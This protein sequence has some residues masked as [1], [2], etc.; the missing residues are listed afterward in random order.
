M[1][2][3]LNELLSVIRTSIKDGVAEINFSEDFLRITA[4]RKKDELID[5]RF[6]A[7][8]SYHVYLASPKDDFCEYCE[9]YFKEIVNPELSLA[10]DKT[11]AIKA[12]EEELEEFCESVR[13]IINSVVPTVLCYEEPIEAVDYIGAK[14]LL[15]ESIE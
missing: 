13:D 4:E 1:N 7:T 12:T 3:Q 15:I 5:L 11:E 10:D 14:K 8:A 2:E 6:D 9:Y